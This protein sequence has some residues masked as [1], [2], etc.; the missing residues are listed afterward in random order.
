MTCRAAITAERVEPLPERLAREAANHCWFSSFRGQYEE[1][2]AAAIRA[3]LEEAAKVARDR[4][5]GMRAVIAI[6]PA[7]AD[8]LGERI[9]EAEEIL[10]AIEVLKT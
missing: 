4:I 5:D 7:S 8:V 1:I 2:I 3:A 9:A 10:A 6:R